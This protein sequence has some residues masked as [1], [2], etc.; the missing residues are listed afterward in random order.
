MSATAVIAPTAPAAIIS[1]PKKAAAAK[2]KAPKEKKAIKKAEHPAWANMMESAVKSLNEKG[3]T[4]IPAIKKYILAN[5]KVDAEHITTHLRRGSKAALASGKLTQAKG[6]G[7]SGSFKLGAGKVKKAAAPAKKTIKIK[8]A[9]AK[10]AASPK[11]S[12]SAKKAAKPKKSTGTPKVA[13][14]GAKP[15]KASAKPKKAGAKTKKITKKIVKKAPSPIKIKTS[16][17]IKA[18]KA[19]KPKTTKKAA[20]K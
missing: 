4:S 1:A 10:K 20:A 8:K 16:K 13:K 9:A 14:T 5:F 7:L 19:P 3:G 12:G 17:K 15:K 2:P 11:K 18:P 6:H